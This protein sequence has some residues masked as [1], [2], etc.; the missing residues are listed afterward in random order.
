MSEYNIYFSIELINF[1]FGIGELAADR[2][3]EMAL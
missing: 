2:Y 1:R 3:Y